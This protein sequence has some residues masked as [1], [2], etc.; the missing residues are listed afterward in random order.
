MK[1]ILTVVFA[2]VA[3]VLALA[4][5]CP[6]E[7]S[8]HRFHKKASAREEG[9]LI[10]DAADSLLGAQERLT[11]SYDDHVLWAMVETRR[12]AHEE[13]YLGVMGIW[14]ELGDG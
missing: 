6:D 14:L 4:F 7:D 8:F 2:I 1:T 10:D 11:A 12:G 3:V 9:S 5:S 13:R